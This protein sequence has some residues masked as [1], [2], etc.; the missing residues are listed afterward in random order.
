MLDVNDD[1]ARALLLSIDP[2]AALAQTHEQIHRRLL[3]ITPTDFEELKAAWE[4]TAESS[5]AALSASPG[6]TTGPAQF[7]D[8]GYV[9]GRE[10]PGGSAESAG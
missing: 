3:E 6:A 5:L 8:P 4:A 9:P 2:L 1:E 7:L 10:A